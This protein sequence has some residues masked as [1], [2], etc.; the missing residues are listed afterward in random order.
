MPELPE[1]ETIRLILEEILPSKR[2]NQIHLKKTRMI[3]GQSESEFKCGL[4][5]RRIIRFDRR[6]KFLL[7]RLD[8]GTLLV[9]LGMS[10]QV[11][12]GSDLD[13]EYKDKV[14]HRLPDKHTH[15]IL[16]LEDDVKVY[17]RD[18]RMFG[19]F[20]W[21]DDS[22][23]KRFFSHLGPEPLSQHFTAR[24]LCSALR[25]RTASI[26]SLLLGQRIVAGLGN[27]YTDEALFR[28]G[29]FPQKPGGELTQKEV[30]ALHRAVRRVVREAVLQGG[31]SVSDFLDPK[32]RRG[33][34]QLALRVYGRSGQPC[35]RCGETI[36]KSTV[37][38]RGTHWC[39]RCQSS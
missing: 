39:P 16:E 10:G 38:Q 27:I 15:M 37:A 8:R 17:F 28:A 24:F 2:I 11:V 13:K 4:Q 1:V 26:K 9:H 18:P 33:T 36:Q 31:T 29:I 12:L 7:I 19:R 14:F 6:G 35:L 3:R 20:A 34:F 32:H 30:R 5:G 21:L 23:E 22:E 25:D